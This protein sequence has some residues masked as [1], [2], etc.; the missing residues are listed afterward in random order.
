MEPVITPTDATLGAVVTAVDLADMN[1]DVW[2]CVENAFH[3]YGVLV[4]PGQNLSE[5]AQ[6]AFACRFGDLELLR[7][8]GDEKAVSIS[9]RDGDGSTVGPD[10]YRYKTLR[11]N[12]GWHTDSSYMP[13]AAKASI[14]SAQV[15]PSRG[16]ET[17]WAD[18][19]AAWDALD[20]ETKTRVES[21]SAYHSLY[22]S[23]AKIGYQ[24][25]TGAG[26]GYHTK[27]A[28]PAAAGQDPSGDRPQV[29]LHRPPRVPNSRNGRRRSA[30]TAGR[31]RRLRVPSAANPRAS[32]AAGRCGDLG[33]SLRAAPG[34]ALRLQRGPRSAPHASRRQPGQR[35]CP[36]GRRR[37]RR[38]VP[39][40]VV[41][42][43]EEG[44]SPGRT[45]TSDMVVNSHPLYQLSYRGTCTRRPYSK[46]VSRTPAAPSLVRDTFLARRRETRHRRAVR[47]LP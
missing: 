10:D 14:L 46:G 16:G 19:R 42:P 39:A 27:G 1:D 4:F 17:E 23:Q 36:N 8:S 24:I 25:Q 28:P 31:A 5:E 40:V 29:A 7:P 41:E 38:C 33:Q 12:E 21:L 6:I 30:G 43:I 32:L 37:A 35:T 22:Q 11:G 20:E 2:R 3:E 26:Y 13:L 9:N 15:V 45:R 18:M 47:P 34:A 44:G